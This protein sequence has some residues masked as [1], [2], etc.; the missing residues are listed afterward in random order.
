MEHGGEAFDAV[1]SFNF[2]NFVRSMPE[3][4]ASFSAHWQSD[5]HSAYARVNY[6][7]EYEN[8]RQG[9]TIDSFAP[10]DLQY[11]YSFDLADSEAALSLGIINA[12]DD[13]PPLVHDGANFNYDPKQ[14]DPR[15]R[16]FYIKVSYSF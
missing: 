16:I 6:A 7:G 11:R 12:F 1:G 2:G 14:H 3:D 8:N 4:K 10:L 15:G 13:E 9:E 5:H